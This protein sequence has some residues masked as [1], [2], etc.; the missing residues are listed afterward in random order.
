MTSFT[1]TNSQ[2]ARNIVVT[3]AEVAPNRYLHRYKQTPL[4]LA[5]EFFAVFAR[6]LFR[7]LSV[8][9]T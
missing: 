5:I 9:G 8:L 4:N 7:S 1:I 2:D 3:E 6:H